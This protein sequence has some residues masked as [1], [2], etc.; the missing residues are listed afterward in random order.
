[1]PELN[2]LLLLYSSDNLTEMDISATVYGVG[3]MLVMGTLWIGTAISIAAPPSFLGLGIAPG[4][5]TS[6][7]MIKA[8]VPYLSG[9]PWASVVHGL[10]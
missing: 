10:W 5:P 4:T 8:G 3:E 7:G 9:A 1:M 2:W 6:G